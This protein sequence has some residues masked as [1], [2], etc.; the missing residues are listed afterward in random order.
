MF[1]EVGYNVYHVGRVHG[2]STVSKRSGSYS[3]RLSVYSSG[4]F[5]WARATFTG[6]SVGGTGSL[7]ISGTWSASN[8]QYANMRVRVFV[9]GQIVYDTGS[10]PGSWTQVTFTVPQSFNVTVW[11]YVWTYSSSYTGNVTLYIDDV[12]LYPIWTCTPS[13]SSVNATHAEYTVT[14]N[15]GVT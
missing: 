1:G 7:Y 10:P 5:A 2:F 8:V 11:I 6:A 4:G 12:T 13:L 9:N 14:N 3:Y 15:W